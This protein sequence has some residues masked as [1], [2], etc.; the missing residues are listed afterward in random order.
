MIVVPRGKAMT[1][2]SCGQGF[3]HFHLHLHLY[4]YRYRYFQIHE[5]DNISH[6]SD[7]APIIYVAVLW[8][9]NPLSTYYPLLSTSSLLPDPI[10]N[11]GATVS[12]VVGATTSQI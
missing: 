11:V 6:W 2:S 7:V 10:S 4:R 8:R 1:S 5:D 12:G 9:P 3:N